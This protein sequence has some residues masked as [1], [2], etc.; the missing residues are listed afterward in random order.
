MRE[1]KGVARTARRRVASSNDVCEAAFHR[2]EDKRA[3][4]KDD[5]W[6]DHREREMG[7]LGC[8]WCSNDQR[9]SSS[10]HV[11]GLRS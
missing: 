6:H 3:K 7:A 5:E 4:Q 1:I 2:L 9:M 11:S 8:G 10:S